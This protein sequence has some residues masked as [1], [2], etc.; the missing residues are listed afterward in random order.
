[1]RILEEALVRPKHFVAGVEIDEKTE[2]LLSGGD[3]KYRRQSWIVDYQEKQLAIEVRNTLAIAKIQAERL[4]SPSI[5]PEHL[6]MALVLD[7]HNRVAQLLRT[8]GINPRETVEMI[9][10]IASFPEEAVAEAELSPKMIQ[11]IGFATAESLKD[12]YNM[13]QVEHLLLGLLQ[14]KEN[15][16]IDILKQ[17]N[18]DLVALEKATRESLQ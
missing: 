12:R 6:L 18:I 10:E 17:Q 14:Q 11:V 8:I 4:S 15:R 1:M 9:M 16:A 5:E 7:E 2:G 13:L 3:S